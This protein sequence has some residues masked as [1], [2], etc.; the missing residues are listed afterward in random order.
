MFD[1]I[2]HLSFSLHLF[3]PSLLLPNLGLGIYSLSELARR[4]LLV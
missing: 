1:A 4:D 2:D 3:R